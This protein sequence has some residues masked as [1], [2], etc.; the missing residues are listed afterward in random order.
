[1]RY[2]INVVCCGALEDGDEEK[3]PRRSVRDLQRDGVQKLAWESAQFHAPN[4]QTASPND[5][6]FVSQP[7]SPADNTFSSAITSLSTANFLSIQQWPVP[8]QVYLST[9]V[10]IFKL[11]ALGQQ[12]ARKT[13][14][15]KTCG[16]TPW[17]R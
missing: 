1:M 8:R 2:V 13:T 7:P 5:P 14:G 6:F 10:D 16:V 9:H 15:G 17:F 3:V 12:T 4:Q 11:I